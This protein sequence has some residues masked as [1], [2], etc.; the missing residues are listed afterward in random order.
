MRR[1]CASRAVT[2]MASNDPQPVSGGSFRR[3]KRS[4][5]IAIL[6]AILACCALF[7]LI[8]IVRMM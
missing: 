2:A 3:R 6:V 7:Y 1:C 8:T 5:N 4:R